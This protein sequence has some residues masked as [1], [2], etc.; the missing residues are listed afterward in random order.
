[1]ENPFY[2]EFG[3]DQNGNPVAGYLTQRANNVASNL[4]KS[5][6]DPRDSAYYQTVS[7]SINALQLGNPA[8]ASNAVSSPIGPGIL[9]SPTQNAIIFSAYESLFLQ[10]EAV[11]RG[12]MQ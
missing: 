10:A 8:N 3:F 2:M 5:L 6:N 11:A 12:W 1:K 9:K 7:G 4:M